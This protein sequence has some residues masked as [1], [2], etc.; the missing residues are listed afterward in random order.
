M[1]YFKEL[2]GSITTEEAHNLNWDFMKRQEAIAD[3][4]SEKSSTIIL[5]PAIRKS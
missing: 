1:N 3:P 5:L 4:K 2:D